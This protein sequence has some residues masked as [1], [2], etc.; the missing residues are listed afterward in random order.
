MARIRER[1]HEFLQDPHGAGF[2]ALTAPVFNHHERIEA[3]VAVIFPYRLD[4]PN[5]ETRHLLP[6]KETALE[7]SRVLGSVEMAN[8]MAA[9][10]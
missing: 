8:K 1:F 7:I 2:S 9:T 4:D 5:R 6:L 3:A 10:L